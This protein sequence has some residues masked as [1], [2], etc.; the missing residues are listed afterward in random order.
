MFLL[1]LNLIFNYYT[2]HKNNANIKYTVIE[3]WLVDNP[4]RLG[5]LILNTKC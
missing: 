2:S 5:Y 3:Q 4:Y 1:Q